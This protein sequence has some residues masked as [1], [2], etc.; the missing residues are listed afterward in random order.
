MS[1]STRQL[2]L[3][4]LIAMS[5]LVTLNRTGHA[6]TPEV[7]TEV[8]LP[9]NESPNDLSIGSPNKAPI[10]PD[11]G[12][13]FASALNTLL[14]DA[15]L[16]SQQQRFEAIVQL[17][18]PVVAQ[19][20][21]DVAIM[22]K[23]AN[24]LHRLQRWDDALALYRR[25][26]QLALPEPSQFGFIEASK[27]RAKALLNIASINLALAQI[28][29]VEFQ[30]NGLPGAEQNQV[31]Q[32]QSRIHEAL[33]GAKIEFA[34]TPSPS[35]LIPSSPSSPSSSLSP[36]QPQPQPSLRPHSLSQRPSQI[37][38]SASSDSAVAVEYLSGGPKHQSP[39]S[40][41]PEARRRAFPK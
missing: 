12:S 37:S 28:A 1:R 20:F 11:R 3:N 40:A 36:L 14:R 7:H 35:L 33:H 34:S 15:E 5:M 22:L 31:L 4:G 17:L 30:R 6:Q 13:G 9:P 38:G 32:A 29:L 26:A 41:V 39:A 21:G 18:T 16:F 23:L 10:G 24:A 2:V 19:G 25:A 8:V 27:A